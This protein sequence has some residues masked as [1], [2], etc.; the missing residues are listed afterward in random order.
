MKA[1]CS[2]LPHLTEQQ[3]RALLCLIPQSSSAGAEHPSPT[4]VVRAR[5]VFRAQGCTA[6]RGAGEGGWRWVRVLPTRNWVLSY[7]ICTSGTLLF[8]LGNLPQGPSHPFQHPHSTRRCVAFPHSTA[9]GSCLPALVRSQR[10]LSSPPPLTFL[11][12]SPLLIFSFGQ[13]SPHLSQIH[14]KQCLSWAHTLCS[15]RYFRAHAQV[16]QNVSSAK[17]CLR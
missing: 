13:P 7:C 2:A 17:Q 6:L 9:A 5:A 16:P 8:L 11:L 12:E 10:Q 1:P 14:C 4:A 3:P 15:P